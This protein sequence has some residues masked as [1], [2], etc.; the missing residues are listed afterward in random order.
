MNFIPVKSENNKIILRIIL[1]ILIISLPIFS[2]FYSSLFSFRKFRIIRCKRSITQMLSYEIGLIIIFILLIFININ[3]NIIEIIIRIS[4]INFLRK[5]II[6]LITFIV[7]LRESRRIPFDFIEG[8]S[9]LVSG[10]NI[11]FSR[12]YFSL[13]F[14]YEYGI[15]LVFSIFNIIIFLDFIYFFILVFSFI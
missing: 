7:I 11:E 1:L 3:I 8:E 6:I 4:K 15:I 10:F 9:E 13:F 5:L 12:S 2:I 14:V